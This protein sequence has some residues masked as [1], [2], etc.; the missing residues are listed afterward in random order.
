MLKVDVL[1]IILMI[2]G[3]NA[4]GYYHGFR[5]EPSTAA[6]FMLGLFCC[7]AT[8]AIVSW[9]PFKNI[10]LQDSLRN[11]SFVLSVGFGVW[12]SLSWWNNSAAV[13][14]EDMRWLIVKSFLGMALG[15]AGGFCIYILRIPERW[16]PDGRFDVIGSSHQFWH[17]MVFAAGVSWC[18]GMLTFGAWAKDNL[19]CN[20]DGLALAGEALAASL[21]QAAGGAANLTASSAAP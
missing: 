6:F 2:F 17:V 4:I 21:V 16:A 3:S 12:P 14:P 1:G 5:C 10:A 18:I 11:A 20:A 8:S 13:L 15:Y 19:T 7:L 9:L